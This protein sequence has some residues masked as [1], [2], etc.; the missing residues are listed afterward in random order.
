MDDIY[1]DA[2]T[3][4]TRLRMRTPFSTASQSSGNGSWAS[5][6]RIEWLRRVRL[7]LSALSDLPTGW[8]GYGAPKIRIETTLFAAQ[9]LQDIWTSRLEVPD[10]SAMSNGGLMIEC[11]RNDFELTIEV[12]G[13][14]A[15]TYLFERPDGQQEEGKIA[16]DMTPLRGFVSEMMSADPVI[17]LVA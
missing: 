4:H 7:R 9:L 5:L 10:L 12:L 1:A 17:A 16:A 2:L 3:E 15:T 6:S 14:Y 8:D 11:N 13:P